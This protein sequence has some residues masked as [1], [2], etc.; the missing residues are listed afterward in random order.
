MNHP[1]C[2]FPRYF[3]GTGLFVSGV[4]L[5]VASQSFAQ[6][7]T[8]AGSGKTPSQ[9]S[10]QSQQE[11][12]TG[13]AMETTTKVVGYVTNRSLMFPDIAT[14]SG[15][16]KTR[17][18]FKL[19]VNQS[20][21]PAYLLAGGIGAAYSQARNV[22]SADRQGWEAFGDRFADDMARASSNSFFNSFVFA[23]L[24]HQDPRFYLQYKPTFWRSVKYSAQRLVVTRND[25]GKDVFNASGVFGTMAA[26]ALANAYLPASEQTAWMS[27][28]R[29]GTDFVWR[30]AGNM[31]KDYW[32]T[33]F[34]RLGLN[35]LQVIPAPTSMTEQMRKPR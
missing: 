21:S 29:V 6:Q 31:F 22:P 34:H 25:A 24:L 33:I 1:H 32:P 19:F 15:H 2:F 11:T 9:D 8:E 28:E 27:L 35:R 7:P 4:L 30:F 5:C 12:S 17:G 10:P 14:N 13:G 23:S 20:I 3:R 26:E 18:K 16:M